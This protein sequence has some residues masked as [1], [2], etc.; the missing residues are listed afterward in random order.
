MTRAVAPQ[1]FAVGAGRER[2]AHQPKELACPHCGAGIALP[3]ERGQVVVCAH[4]RSEVELTGEEARAIGAVGEPPEGLVLPVGAPFHWEGVRYEVVGRSQRCDLGEPEYVTFGYLLYHPQ[5]PSRWLS[6]YQNQWTLG[7]RT[8]VMPRG[9]AFSKTEGAPLQSFDNRNWVCMEVNTSEL[10]YVDGA[11][12]WLAKVGDQTVHAEFHASGDE[13]SLY[14]VERNAMGE[15]EQSVAQRLSPEQ[16][17]EATE[18]A[19]AASSVLTPAMV[20][21]WGD[22]PRLRL[23]GL[24]W[25]LFGVVCL[26]TAIA[27]SG[28]IRQLAS[29]SI[30]PTGGQVGP[31]NTTKPNTILEIDVRQGFDKDGWSFVEGEVLDEEEQYLFGF[32]DELWAESG[33]DEGHWHEEKNHFDLKVTIPEPGEYYLGFVTESSA[34]GAVVGLGPSAGGV[35][36]DINITISAHRASNVLFWAAGIIGVLAGLFMWEAATGRIR[37]KLGDIE[38][39]S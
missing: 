25:L 9:D 33:Y 19:V 36:R 24:I 26:I 17:E 10:L 28:G 7:R 30:P 2:P 4:C 1:R 39:E 27:L 14:E 18:G 12:P 38:V 8:R 13:D 16:M 15:I 29:G 5:H 37:K 22:S 3:D 11:L 20:A 23:V 35:G 32:G 21:E 6:C 34:Q 31:I